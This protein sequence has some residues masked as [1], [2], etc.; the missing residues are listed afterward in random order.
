MDTSPS[1]ASSISAVRGRAR[2]ASDRASARGS[3][4]VHVAHAPFGRASLN[5]CDTANALAVSGVKAVLTNHDVPG[6]AGEL[7]ASTDIRFLGHPVA[8]VIAESEEAAAAGA[9]LLEIDCEPLPP[10]ISIED[11]IEVKSFHGE[12]VALVRGDFDA[13]ISESADKISGEVRCPAQDPLGSEPP[14][15]HAECDGAGG[16]EILV[17]TDRP[18]TIQERIAA[19][20]G[21]GMSE[22]RVRLPQSVAGSGVDNSTPAAFAA[23]AAFVTGHSVAVRYSAE[24]AALR[25]GHR[26]AALA[27]YQAGFDAE[28]RISA[29]AVN[30]Y[31]DGGSV[32][33][34]AKGLST[35]ALHHLDNAYWLPH[36]RF[37]VQVCRTHLPPQTEGSGGVVAQSAVVIEEIIN[38]VARRIGA[39]PEV[40][41]QRNFYSSEGIATKSPAGVSV[42]AS[43]LLSVWK[44][45]LKSSDFATRRKAIDTAN[46]RNQFVKRGIA[47]VPLKLALGDPRDGSVQTA[48]LVHILKDGSVQVHAPAVDADIAR[49]ASATIAGELGAA[50]DKIRVIRASTGEVTESRNGTASYPQLIGQAVR[51]ACTRLRNLLLPLIVRVFQENGAA[52]IG[53]DDLVFLPGRIA[54]RSNPDEGFSFDAFA[55][56]ASAHNMDLTSTGSAFVAGDAVPYHG[57]AFG[58]AVS[59]VQIDSFTGEYRV[60][61]SDVIQQTAH[62]SD[63]AIANLRGGFLQ[64]LGWVTSE[65]VERDEDGALGSPV[66]APTIGDEPLDC[67]VQV[68]E[69]AKAHGDLRTAGIAL[70]L[71]VREA[72]KD[73]IVA[74]G[75][76]AASVAVDLAIPA[77]P[78]SVFRQV[79][80]QRSAAAKA[81]AKPKSESS[82]D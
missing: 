44:G 42:T 34:D 1:H 18:S 4:S 80:R 71:S 46:A 11:A 8:L 16:I 75:D 51:N 37:G 55:R 53:T 21:I 12:P 26:P 62:S 31:I 20:L 49:S 50:P 43:Q 29:V 24:E 35:S 74:F 15:A 65:L 36:V 61:R 27:R 17:G 33:E 13:M 77:S 5:G 66:L 68:I 3:L 39:L 19:M 59:E 23:L 25:R 41:R 47:A 81:K 60:L 63:I 48:V 14:F 58:L 56:F 82:S 10:V 67:R 57:F 54:N 78:E 64:G 6:E 76:S 79:H 9:R 73:A 28:G 69:S 32:S 7:F 70:A 40:I 22:V 38:R 45:G 52:G 2:F 72:L 30:V